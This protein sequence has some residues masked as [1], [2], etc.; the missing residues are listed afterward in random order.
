MGIVSYKVRKIREKEEDK[1]QGKLYICVPFNETAAGSHTGSFDVFVTRREMLTCL[2][3]FFEA[4]QLQM[5][6]I[7][8]VRK[9]QAKAK[10]VAMIDPRRIHNEPSHPHPGIASILAHPKCQKAV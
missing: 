7:P 5:G 4:R 3:Y 9:F 6:D 10:N 2:H 8:E 1:T